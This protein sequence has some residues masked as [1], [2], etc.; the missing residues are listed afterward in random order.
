MNTKR[1]FLAA[2]TV[3]IGLHF[4]SAANA[5]EPESADA[6]IKERLVRNGRPAGSM[7]NFFCPNGQIHLAAYPLYAELEPRTSSQTTAGA[8]GYRFTTFPSDVATIPWHTTAIV[9]GAAVLG[10]ANWNWGSSSFTFNDEGFF[11]EDTGSLGMDKLGHAYS[12]YL[13]SDFFNHYM[14]KKGASTYA[15][16]NAAL[17]SWGIMLGVEVFD[18]FSEDHGFSYEDLIFNFFG[19][20]FSVIRNIVPG[21]REKLDFRLEYIPSGNKDGFHPITDYSGQKYVLALKLSGFDL[22]KK[23]PLRF[24]ELQGGYFARGFTEKEEE[25]GDP[26]RREPYVAIGINLSELFFGT[27]KIG[28][29]KFGHYA[30]RFLEYVQVPYT[31]V[32]TV[33]E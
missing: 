21:L 11:G 15:P 10:I 18:G 31:Y 6:G 7:E 26:L 2:V 19:A 17:L 23:T 8:N 33:N 25:E 24:L 4:I 20:S 30:S 1:K 22:C 3:F 28:K 13:I 14:Q 29:T 27:T 16:Y 9:A 32:A 5:L 12:T